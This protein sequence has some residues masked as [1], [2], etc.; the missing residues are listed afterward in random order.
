MKNRKKHTWLALLLIVALSVMSGC[1]AVSGLD[2]NKVMQNSLSVKSLE[3]SQTIALEIVPNPL[4]ASISEQDKKAFELFSNV[5]LSIS[6][7]KQQDYTHVSLKGVFEYNKGKIPFQLTLSDQDYTIM[8]EGAKKPIVIHGNGA[9]QQAQQTMSPEMQDLMKQMQQK[10]I[11]WYPSFGSYLAGIS[12]N[13]NQISTSK[14]SGFVGTE[15]VNG[16]KIHA[17]I[18]GSELID[19]TKKFLTNLLT[20]EKG[21]KDLLGQLYDL[22]A[23]LVKQALKESGDS[24][25]PYNSMITPYLNNKTLAVEFAFTF[26]TSNLKSVLEN[27]D[28]SVQ[29]AMDSYQG[30]S[31]KVL[32]SDQ[33]QLKTDLFVDSDMML[34]KSTSEFMFTLPADNT[35]S[36]QS[37]KLTATAQNWNLNK[38]VKADVIDKSAGEIEIKALSKP[39]Q[40]LGALDPQSKLYELLK[41]DLH[42]SKKEINL[43]MDNSSS[44]NDSTKPYIRNGVTMVPARFVVEEL[45]AEVSWNQAT[46]QITIT[47]P[48]SGAVITLNIGSKQA[49]VNGMIKPLE[50][51]AELK[52]GTT[53]IPVRFIAENLG[54]KV[55]WNQEQQMVTISRD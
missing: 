5:K 38:P 16:T 47:D 20:D 36:V 6:D 24:N 2:L 23:P 32:L 13:P 15:I 31:L 55:S 54:T 51:E 42:I 43:L 1:Q 53:F 7:I 45:D 46:Q 10:L 30:D 17:E 44:L 8:V 19:L 39:G 41:Y 35:S 50:T 28:A 21:L 37:V 40:V 3:G 12:P 48:L 14:E 18:K 52:D 4:A 29:S 26:I 25:N 22:F 9:F 49:T 33:V 27:Y 11:E 34:R